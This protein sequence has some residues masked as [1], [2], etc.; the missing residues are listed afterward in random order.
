M[1]RFR[2][3]GADVN[4]QEWSGAE[5]L[6]RVRDRMEPQRGDRVRLGRPFGAYDMLRGIGSVGGFNAVVAQGPARH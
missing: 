4:S 5:P 1:I 2:P 3:N 6:V